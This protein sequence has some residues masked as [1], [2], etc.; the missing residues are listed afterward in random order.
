M[1]LHLENILGYR[2][3]AYERGQVKINDIFYRDH[4]IIMPNQLLTWTI[5]DPLAISTAEMD[6][7]LAY[8]PELIVLGTGASQRF[9]HRSVMEAVLQAGIGLEVMT[10]QT[11]CYTYNIVAAEGRHVA[12]A[13][14]LGQY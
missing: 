7:I 14:L 9:P 1:K 4:L 5:A 12:A 11:A 13:L 3:Q 2:I 8:R 10:T 6:V